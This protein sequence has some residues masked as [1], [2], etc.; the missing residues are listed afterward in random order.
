MNVQAIE[1]PEER[2]Q[3]ELQECIKAYILYR[4]CF[5]HLAYLRHETKHG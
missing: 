4:L 1:R 5:I 2:A 3:T